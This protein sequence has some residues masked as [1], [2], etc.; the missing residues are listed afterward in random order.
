M[1]LY[2]FIHID[3]FVHFLLLQDDNRILYLFI[4][5]YAFNAIPQYTNDIKRY[6][7]TCV[8]KWVRLKVTQC[9][10]LELACKRRS[11]YKAAIEANQCKSNGKGL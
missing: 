10:N 7:N 8:F 9:I 3:S 4:Y 1:F 5:F 6:Q 11:G 2:T